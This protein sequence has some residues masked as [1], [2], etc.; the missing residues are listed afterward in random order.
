MANARDEMDAIHQAA[1]SAKIAAMNDANAS[2]QADVNQLTQ[3]VKTLGEA[4]V[5]RR[6]NSTTTTVI[7]TQT[8]TES[9]SQSPEVLLA[10]ETS[11]QS[12]T[13]ADIRTAGSEPRANVRI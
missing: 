3:Q 1:T 7:T 11:V 4:E 12:T 5:E 6:M 2:I 13:N 10:K 9:H 8:H